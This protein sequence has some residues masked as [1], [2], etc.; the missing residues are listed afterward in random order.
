[1]SK[2][3]IASF[4]VVLSFLMVVPDFIAYAE[5]VK[6][7]INGRTVYVEETS[8]SKDSSTLER[9]DEIKDLQTEEFKK[10]LEE[11]RAEEERRRQEE[12]ERR[13]AEE[14]ASR[15]DPE[16]RPSRGRDGGYE[17]PEDYYC[18]AAHG[19]ISLTCIYDPSIT[20]HFNINVRKCSEV[21]E[22]C[23]A[24]NLD[25]NEPGIK[26]DVFCED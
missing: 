13:R 5:M 11:R 9:E 21:A 23:R 4:I 6:K 7:V 14:E 8:N 17:C 2:K 15:P 1:M 22:W 18:R 19:G 12:E 20:G 24:P 3:S 16:V 26:Y 10:M 25:R